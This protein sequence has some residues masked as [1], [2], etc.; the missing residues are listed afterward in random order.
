MKSFAVLLLSL[1]S[2]SVCFAKNKPAPLSADSIISLSVK[3]YGHLK[4]Y[5]DSGKLVQTF[6]TDHPHK[7][8]TVFKTA[9]VNTGDINFEYYIPGNSNSLYTINRTNNIVKT[10]W[11]IVNR[12][13]APVSMPH[14]LGAA[15]GVSGGTSMIVPELLL[16]ADFKNNNLYKNIT[17][18]VLAA[19][20]QVNGKDCYK[21]TGTNLRGPITIWI[22]K[23]DFLI[24]KI[25]DEHVVD[26]AKTEAISHKMDSMMKARGGAMAK[27]HETAMKNL[28]M[29][30]KMDSL[31][32]KQAQSAFT[33][34][35]TLS[36]FPTVAGKV[37]PELLKFRPNREV[38]L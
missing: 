30:H 12:T 37:N 28:A 3:A 36:F 25:E 33:V 14:A 32:G 24:R 29:I 20:E 26:P 2:I 4:T 15:A 21:I 27:A 7:T 18:R 19:V 31:R 34:K 8:A 10:W 35:E 1:L 13:D 38:A 5:T 22:G 11:G 17:K 9:Y 23:K 16:T 6:L